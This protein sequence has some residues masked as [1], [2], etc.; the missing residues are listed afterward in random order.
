VV[1]GDPGG[2][3]GEQVLGVP[4]QDA[5]PVGGFDQQF[6]DAAGTGE[7]AHGGAVQAQLHA[8]RHQRAPRCDQVLHGG[9]AVAGPGDQGA[10][11]S[12]DVELTARRG[13]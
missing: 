8:D 13:R 3:P 6:V 2:E 5:E 7:A 9:V 11:A 4:V 10:F 12:A 1:S